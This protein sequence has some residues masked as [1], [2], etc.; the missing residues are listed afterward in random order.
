[1]LFRSIYN[2]CWV[3][4]EAVVQGGHDRDKYVRVEFKN[5]LSP[6]GFVKVMQNGVA[7]K[8]DKNG[9]PVTDDKG[10]VQVVNKG[11]NTT[12]KAPTKASSAVTGK[13]PKTGEF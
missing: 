8:V 11:T 4:I 1:M 3:V 6:V 10:N 7:V 12:T 5:G 2:N 13:S 9:V